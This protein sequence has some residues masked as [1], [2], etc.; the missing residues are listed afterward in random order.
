[1]KMSHH[2]SVR[3]Q[4][5]A[6]PPMLIDLLLQFGKSEPAGGGASK[7]YFDKA[8]RRRVKSYA[9]QL[10]GFLDEHLDVYAVVGTDN[11]IITA[12]HLIERIHRH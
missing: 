1:M 3:C 4:Q 12:A 11:Q 6:I 5:R 7:M 10:A 8:A 9:G 2:A